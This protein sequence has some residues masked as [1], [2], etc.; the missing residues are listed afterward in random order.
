M[1]RHSDDLEGSN[2]DGGDSSG[3]IPGATT[4]TDYEVGK[5]KEK[6]ANGCIFAQL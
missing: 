6:E 3:T 1:A 2:S 5:E 4:V